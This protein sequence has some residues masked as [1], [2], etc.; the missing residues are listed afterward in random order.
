MER[1][2]VVI[3]G[4]GF[5]GLWTA[6][7]PAAWVLCS[8]IHMAKHIGLRNQ[9]LVLVNGD[10]SY[11]FYRRAVRLILQRVREFGIRGGHVL[12]G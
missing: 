1:P 5:G 10:W 6:L 7:V 11:L 8:V 4:A 2:S 12:D 9:E 3:V